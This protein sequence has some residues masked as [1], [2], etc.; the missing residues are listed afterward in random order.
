MPSTTLANNLADAA[1]ADNFLPA[2][3]HA[4]SGSAGTLISTCALYPLSLVVTRLQRQRQQQARLRRR[5]PERHS[6]TSRRDDDE[7]STTPTTGP[8]PDPSYAG[9]ADAFSGIWKSGGGLKAFYTGLGQDAIRSALDSFLFFLF[10]D[11]ILSSRPSRGRRR[12]GKGGSSSHDLGVLEELAIGVVAG[13]CSKFFSTPLTNLASQKGREESFRDIIAAIRKEKGITGLWSGYS[14]SLVLTLNPS[15]ALFLQGFLKRKA[16]KKDNP[17]AATSF[18]LAAISKAIATTITYPLQTA[19]ARVQDDLSPAARRGGWEEV[20]REL[21]AKHEAERAAAE[22]AARE[23]DDDAVSPK[24]QSPPIIKMN[25]AP[26]ERN[27]TDESKL[28]AQ[29]LRAVKNLGR[30]SIFATVVRIARTEGIGALYEG[31]H[32]EL[33]TAFF[34]HGVTMSAKD[35]VHRLL[36]RLYFIAAG[37]L[38]ELKARRAR[39]I[40]LQKTPKKPVVRK[41]TKTVVEEEIVRG[42]VRPTP[43]PAARALEPPVPVAVPTP[44]PKV[45]E[46]PKA[47]TVIVSPPTPTPSPPVSSTPSM[48]P[49]TISPPAPQRTLPPPATRPALPAPT[50][51][52]SLPSSARSST[53]SL[54]RSSL[55]PP[56]YSSTPSLTPRSSYTSPPPAY[57]PPTRATL[58]PQAPPPP[59]QPRTQLRALRYRLDN[60]DEW[61]PR[62]TSPYASLIPSP[63]HYQQQAPATTLPYQQAPKRR[64]LSKFDD[65]VVGVVANMIDK[66]QREIKH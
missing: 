18:L 61:G 54:D 45:V 59:S 41:V 19:L 38:A 24:S 56:A 39:A 31:L 34:G 23:H 49:A 57:S 17:G 48:P 30:Q 15:I 35:V 37:V 4:I 14:A 55:P 10:Y 33:L 46:A 9:L 27:S 1:A 60:E 26:P 22:A 8:A 64:S 58:S 44:M 5:G 21:E 52:T 2:L 32:L 42:L 50:P 65:F 11:W 20:V 7:G 3:H 36:F 29:A 47:P 51:P 53:S 40:N 12:G 62:S 63:K 66:T 43:A 6:L 16:V 13:A 25:V 28:E